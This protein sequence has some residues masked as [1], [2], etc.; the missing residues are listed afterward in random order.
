M[1]ETEVS[2]GLFDMSFAQGGETREYLL[3]VQ[4]LFNPSEGIPPMLS[5]K[6]FGL[7][8]QSH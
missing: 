8:S 3:Y 7:V 4:D 6:G 2:R 1:T 5:F